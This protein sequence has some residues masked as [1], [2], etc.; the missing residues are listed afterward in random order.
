LRSFSLILFILI[1]SYT[2]LCQ[3]DTIVYKQFGSR[4]NY[5]LIFLY[6]DNTFEFNH[7]SGSC[8]SSYSLYGTWEAESNKIIFTDSLY[9]EEDAL[10]IKKSVKHTNH[11]LITIKNDK[12]K[13]LEGIKISYYSI[14]SDEQD[15]ITDKKG[16]IRIDKKKIKNLYDDDIN[17]SIWYSNRKQGECFMSTGFEARFDKISITIVENPKEEHFTRTTVYKADCSELHF[18][19]WHF[20]IDKEY[21]SRPWGNFRLLKENIKGE[22]DNNTI[23]SVQRSQ[24]P[25]PASM[26]FY[27]T[28]Q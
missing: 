18:E 27:T 16:E 15:H 3:K 6:P 13:P 23:T 12:G 4:Y 9:W 28:H 5:N 2:G 26:S 19:S 17:F 22:V 14:S 24:T 20:S 8:W 11:V 21:F 25:A 10:R 7:F 1:S